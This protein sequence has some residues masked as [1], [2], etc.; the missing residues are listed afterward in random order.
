MSSLLCLTLSV[1]GRWT[2]RRLIWNIDVYRDRNI[3]WPA[4]SFWK[5][6]FYSWSL[7]FTVLV[8]RWTERSLCK[9]TNFKL[10]QLFSNW[11]DNHFCEEDL[12]IN[13]NYVIDRRRRSFHPG[14]YLLLM[15]DKK[16]LTKKTTSRR[17]VTKKS[18]NKTRHYPIQSNTT[19][20]TQNFE[21]NNKIIDN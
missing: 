10:R 15:K 4:S 11:E 9:R 18:S 17:V 5:R 1:I 21:S 16:S 19:E 13:R 20:I 7:S 3:M 14:N 12:G 2:D 8:L 6:D